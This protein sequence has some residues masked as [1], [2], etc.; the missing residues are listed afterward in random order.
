MSA[1]FEARV[2]CVRRWSDDLF[3]LTTTRDAGF[4]FGS[5]QFTM[6]GLEVDGRRMTR[7]FSMV[8][9]H[10]DDHL[11][12]LGIRVPG[13]GLSPRLHQLREGD[14]VVVGRKPTGTLVLEQ[15]RPG[16][17]LYLLSTGT[18]IAPFMSLIKDPEPYERFETVV[19]VHGCR[20]VSDLAYR[21]VITRE[22]PQHEL[23]GE[24][25]RRQLRY[26]PTVT[27]EPFERQGRITHLMETGQ[28]CRDMELPPLDP[29]L[30]RVMI[31]GSPQMLT[32]IRTLL[33]ARGFEAGH[34]GEPGHYVYEK[35]FAEK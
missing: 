28:L 29:E 9:A 32:D 14:E 17:H 20:R 6:L 31:C 13:G 24:T 23:I 11:E 30:D 2:L 25:V 5:G 21:D 35:A 10:Y 18:G 4:R 7:A 15:L 1:F 19:L 8:S 12:F 33:E 3:S 27:R 22:L 16:R 26:C 34:P